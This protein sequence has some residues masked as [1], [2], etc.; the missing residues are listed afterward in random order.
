[1]RVPV[2]KASYG[3][4]TQVA[5]VDLLSV[6]GVPFTLDGEELTLQ[7]GAFMT[8]S[9]L[10]ENVVDVNAAKKHLARWGAD[11]GKQA[12]AA[13]TIAAVTGAG[14]VAGRTA[15]GDVLAKIMST[16]KSAAGSWF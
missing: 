7:L 9:L 4:F 11:L 15:I 13:G 1:M 14:D 3:E 6:L 2:A 12:V 16:L 10:D 8:K 5:A